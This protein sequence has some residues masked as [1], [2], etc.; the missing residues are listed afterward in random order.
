M[1]KPVRIL[2]HNQC[3]GSGSRSNPDPGGQKWPTKI[4]KKF[5]ISFF[6]VLDVRF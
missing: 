5:K 3:C 1:S 4:E 2:L 6:E